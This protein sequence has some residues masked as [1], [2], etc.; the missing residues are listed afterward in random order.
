[1][2]LLALATVT[3]QHLIVPTNHRCTASTCAFASEMFK[4]VAVLN[5]GTSAVYLYWSLSQDNDE[6]A[7]GIDA[8]DTNGWVAVGISANGGGCAEAGG[9][10]EGRGREG[11]GCCR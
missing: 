8:H 4:H 11:Q 3:T 10:C 2:L 7:I 9:G 5:S 6:I 1:M